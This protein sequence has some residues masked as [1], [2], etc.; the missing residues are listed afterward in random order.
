MKPIFIKLLLFCALFFNLEGNAKTIFVKMDG[1][2]NGESWENALSNLQLAIDIAADSDQIWIKTGVYYPTKT[3]NRQIPFLIDKSV[4][5]FGGFS[6]IEKA[7]KER[8]FEQFQTIISGE[9]GDKTSTLDN[10]YNI[11]LIDIQKGDIVLDG[12]TLRGGMANISSIASD[13]K[14]SGAGIF[15]TTNGN[16]SSLWISN[17]LFID[18]QALYGGAISALILEGGD[19][20]IHIEN[21][22]FQDNFA[23]IEGGAIYHRASKG[24]T[25]LLEIQ[26]TTFTQNLSTFGGAIYHKAEKGSISSPRVSFSDFAGNIAYVRGSCIYN[27][28]DDEETGSPLFIDCSFFDNKETVGNS[29]GDSNNIRKSQNNADRMIIRPTLRANSKRKIP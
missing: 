25:D 24:S 11:F 7:L 1:K 23:E 6:G 20:N 15:Y 19:A 14:S 10:S 17:C 4:Q 3:N 5:I 12:I 13:R 28:L 8:D 21:C 26:Y 2:G 18:N 29:M 9:I 16:K 27:Q 22:V